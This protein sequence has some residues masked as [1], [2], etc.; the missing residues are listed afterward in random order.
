L[1]GQ[2]QKN[3]NKITIGNFA[4]TL[5]LSRRERGSFLKISPKGS[6]KVFQ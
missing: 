2:V 5:T 3:K 4:L 1:T 6:G